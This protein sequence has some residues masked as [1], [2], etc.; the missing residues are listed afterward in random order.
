M[1]AKDPTGS[2]G[3]PSQLF[4]GETTLGERLGVLHKQLID[5]LPATTF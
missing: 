1:S 4:D 2:Y 5:T 3:I